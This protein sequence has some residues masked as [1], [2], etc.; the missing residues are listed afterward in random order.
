MLP[1]LRADVLEVISRG[2]A[3]QRALRPYFGRD[4][5]EVALVGISP[6]RL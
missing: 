6:R 5:G 1:N 3:S 2:G 4:I